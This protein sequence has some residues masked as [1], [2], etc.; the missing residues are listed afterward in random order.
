MQKSQKEVT[1]LNSGVV[2]A[3]CQ[4]ATFTSANTFNHAIDT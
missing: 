1:H 4:T 2:M 3:T